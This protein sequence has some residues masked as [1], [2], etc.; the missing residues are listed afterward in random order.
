MTEYY[1]LPVLFTEEERRRYAAWGIKKEKTLLPFGIIAAIIEALGLAALVIYLLG[2]RSREPY[3]SAYLSVWGDFIGS[4]QFGAVLIVTFLILKPLDLLF[5]LIFKKPADPKM[6]RIEPREDGVVYTLSCKEKVLG[7]GRLSW[8]EWKQAVIPVTNQITIDGQWLTIGANTIETIYPRE[9]RR[10]WMDRPAE[11]I[12]GTI[13]LATIQKN[14]EG[15]R[16]SLEEKK[17]EME[18]LRNHG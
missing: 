1:N 16:A 10:L 4:V 18:W 8:E 5:D 15:Y 7:Q 11:K 13:Q 9:K 17:K 6:L 3:F 2:V 14:L 12:D